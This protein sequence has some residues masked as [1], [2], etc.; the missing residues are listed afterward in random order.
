[1]ALI[2]IT[3]K[4]QT[5]GQVAVH[6]LDNPQ[7]VDGAQMTPAQGVA[8]AALAAIHHELNDPIRQPVKKLQLVGADEM[9]L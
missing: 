8:C 1:M 7:V 5:D 4:D 3:I 2:V 6:M 9:P